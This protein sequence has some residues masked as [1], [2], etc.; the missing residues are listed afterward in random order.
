MPINQIISDV[1]HT[2]HNYADLQHGQDIE[3]VD[4][5][6]II[7]VCDRAYQFRSGER[8]FAPANVPTPKVWRGKPQLKPAVRVGKKLR[9]VLQHQLRKTFGGSYGGWHVAQ[10]RPG[11]ND[12]QRLKK[13]WAKPFG[14]DAFPEPAI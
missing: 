9:K 6:T 10:P 4:H 12:I 13:K 5:I 7:A 14:C 11:A 3:L 2:H 1:T 8:A